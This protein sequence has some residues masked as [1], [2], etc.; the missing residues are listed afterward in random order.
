M[1]Q[2]HIKDFQNYQTLDYQKELSNS[3]PCDK[4]AYNAKLLN[5]SNAPKH[6]C[7]NENEKSTQNHH[8][9]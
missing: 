9:I 5:R 7:K 3:Q 1:S 8:L 2:L 4:N 6:Y